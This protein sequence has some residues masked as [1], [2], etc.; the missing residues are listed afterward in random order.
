MGREHRYNFFQEKSGLGRRIRQTTW[1]WNTNNSTW[2]VTEDLKFVSDALLFG[3][4][5]AELQP[6]D[7]SLVRSYAWGLDLSGPMDGAGGVG[8][9]LWVTL[10]TAPGAAAG[11]HFAAYDGNGNVVALSAAS[12]GSPTAR[13]EYGPF[14]EPIRVTGPAA[15]LNP[16]RFST[17]RTDPTTDLVLYEYRVYSP[18]LGRWLSRDPI[19]EDASANL[20][21]AFRN[22]PGT[23]MDGFGLY[24]CRSEGF[25][26]RD[27]AYGMIWRQFESGSRST[28]DAFLDHWAKALDLRYVNAICNSGADENTRIKIEVRDPCCREY[29]VTCTFD[30]KAKVT[31]L[32]PGTRP[33]RMTGINLS[34]NILG[35]HHNWHRK[36]TK[37]SDGVLESASFQ[38][39]ASNEGYRSRPDLEDITN[40]LTR[41]YC[42]PSGFD[43]WREMAGC[44]L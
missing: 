13:Y 44:T 39:G 21:A 40:R 28:C 18:A 6:S 41:N 22:D 26:A 43:G 12:D 33:N 42:R 8:G 38:G 29:R 30:Y 37:G 10:H 3:R 23:Y 5:I 16:Y 7:N 14:G 35:E 4:H 27:P 11:T 15:T 1:T 19:E 31:Q 36:A 9:L 34:V 2:L 20:S 25:A 24:E 32:A 17:K